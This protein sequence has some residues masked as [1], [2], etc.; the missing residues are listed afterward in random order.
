MAVSSSAVAC[1]SVAKSSEDDEVVGDEEDGI[2]IQLQLRFN[3][4]R[5]LIITL[6]GHK[7]MTQTCYVVLSLCPSLL[8]I[9]GEGEREK[10]KREDEELA[11]RRSF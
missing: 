1:S 6:F 4:S 10:E 5:A 8:R 11:S 3:D 7:A 9:E 2:F